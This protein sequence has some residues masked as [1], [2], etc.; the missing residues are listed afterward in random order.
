MLNDKWRNDAACD[1]W[2]VNQF[3]DKYEEDLELRPQIDEY[4]NDCPV[5]RQCFAAGVGNKEYGVWGGVYLEKG[6]VSREFN[7]HKTKADWAETWQN[8]TMDKE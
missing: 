7:R 3:F 8:L 5:M 4:C 2:E 1:E 6:K